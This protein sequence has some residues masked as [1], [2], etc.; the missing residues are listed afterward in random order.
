MT[1]PYRISDAER[2]R[3]SERMQRLHANPEF[4]AKMAAA[5]SENMTRLNADPEFAAKRAAALRE[6]KK[7]QAAARRWLRESNPSLQKG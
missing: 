1:R 3:R 5:A 6:S 2:R 4:A 7:R